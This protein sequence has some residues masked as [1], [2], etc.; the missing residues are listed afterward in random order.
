MP[1][2]L[3]AIVDLLR[4]HSGRSRASSQGRSGGRSQSRRV[5]R[6]ARAAGGA[7]GARA[8]DPR[9][10]RALAVRAPRHGGDRRRSVARHRLA[11]RAPSPCVAWRT[12]R[13]SCSRPCA[14][15]SGKRRSAGPGGQRSG[16]QLTAIEL[17]GLT[18]GRSSISSAPG[19]TCGSEAAARTRA[20]HFRGQPDVRARAR[21]V[22]SR[23]CRERRCSAAVPDSL[24]ELVR[25]AGC[26]R[27]EGADPAGS[28][29][30]SPRAADTRAARARVRVREQPAS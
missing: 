30:R 12:L 28:A 29:G 24:R 7:V 14:G 3:G 17:G 16:E 23:P 2:A 20:S 6:P 15:E 25:V 9:S 4:C 1:L 13:S 18:A 26:S 27:A 11:A 10:F 5:R 22:T 21:A 8:G 19:S